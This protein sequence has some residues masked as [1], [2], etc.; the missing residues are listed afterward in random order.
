M[1]AMA[2]FGYLLTDTALSGL[3]DDR[4]YPNVIPVGAEHPAIA[5]QLTDEEETE[6]HQGPA[7][8]YWEEYQ[9]TAQDVTHEGVLAVEEALCEALDAWNPETS[10]G[11]DYRVTRC[12]RTSKMDGYNFSGETFTRRIKYEIQY[13]ERSA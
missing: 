1:F 7:G 8:V 9:F 3:I 10:A 11:S 5:Y 13:K 6:T 12:K 4:L 2:L